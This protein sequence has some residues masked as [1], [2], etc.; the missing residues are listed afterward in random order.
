MN[1]TLAIGLFST[2]GV[3]CFLVLSTTLWA[4]PL[5]PLQMSNNDWTSAWLMMTVLDYYGAALPLCGIAVSSEPGYNGWLWSMGFCF[6]GSPFCCA[7]VV[8]K[9]ISNRE[10]G[11]RLRF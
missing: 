8:L 3:V 5:F 6:G 7:Y 2:L 11:L 10:N 1:A 4:H 9:L